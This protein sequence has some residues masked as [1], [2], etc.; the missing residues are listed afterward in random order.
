[1]NG[2]RGGIPGWD[3]EVGFWNGIPGAPGGMPPGILERDPGRDPGV[4]S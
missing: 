2:I 1:M 3:P 4:G